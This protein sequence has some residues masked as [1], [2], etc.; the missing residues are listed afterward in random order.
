MREGGLSFLSCLRPHWLADVGLSRDADYQPLTSHPLGKAPQGRHG[1]NQALITDVSVQPPVQPTLDSFR[2]SCAR[3][4]AQP[5]EPTTHIPKARLM[6]GGGLSFLSCPRPSWLAN[7]GLSRDTDYR[8]PDM[9]LAY[10]LST[11]E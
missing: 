5:R 2:R 7:V 3:G 8:L 1:P 11:K 10:I 4:P 9:M 6:G